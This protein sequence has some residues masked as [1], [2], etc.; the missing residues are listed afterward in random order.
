MSLKETEYTYDA[1]ICYRR[2]DLDQ[3]IAARLHRMLSTYRVP[4]P[5]VRAGGR[6]RL[7]PIFRDQE[8]LP[9]SGSLSNQL[10]AELRQSRCLLV[11]C[12]PR[13]PESK[14]IDAEIRYF[15][16][17]GREDC[18]LTL[19]I[20]GAP[21]FGDA[22]P[23]VLKDGE[24]SLSATVTLGAK[25]GAIRDAAA[26][27]AALRRTEASGKEGHEDDNIPAPVDIRDPDGR[28][29][30]R[31][32]RREK[33]KLL[34]PLLGYRVGE[35]AQREVKRRLFRR[36]QLVMV[37]TTVA[38]TLAAT[39]YSGKQRV[40]E[41]AAVAM[42]RELAAEA[43]GYFDQEHD[44]ALLLAVEACRVATTVEASASLLTG[45]Q[46]F[47]YLERWF[48]GHKEPVYAVTI[49]PDG[50][51]IASG[52]GARSE[53]LHSMA[54]VIVESDIL[55][56][57]IEGGGPPIRRY[58][59]PDRVERLAFHPTADVVAAVCFDGRIFLCDLANDTT[60]CLG[61]HKGGGRA[62]AFNSDGSRLASVGN[63]GTVLLWDTVVRR[64][65][66]W[67]LKLH[68]GIIWDVAFQPEG[69]LLVTVGSDSRIVL[70][71]TVRME[72]HAVLEHA[73]PK[74]NEQRYI[75]NG[76]K[77]VAFDPRGQILVSG[78][79]GGDIHLWDVATGSHLAGPLPSGASDIQGLAFAHDGR[80]L[81]AAANKE[82]VIYDTEERAR[83]DPPLIG[84]RSTVYRVSFSSNGQRLVSCSQDG[85]VALWDLTSHEA[86]SR[87]TLDGAMFNV[88]IP[89]D[90][91]VVA[92]SSGNGVEWWDLLTEERFGPPT[93]AHL[94]SVGALASSDDGRLV[95]SASDDH[96]V[97]WNV[98]TRKIHARL[99]SRISGD[100]SAVAF[101]PDASLLVAS[102]G[103]VQSE[104]E[105][106]SA[107][108]SDEE[109]D[110]PEA[111]Q[112]PSFGES[113]PEQEVGG[114]LPVKSEGLL[115]VWK[116]PEYE[117]C[118]VR[119]PTGDLRSAAFTPDDKSLIT[120]SWDGSLVV[121]EVESLAKGNPRLKVI[122]V[123]RRIGAIAMHPD[124]HL[125]AFTSGEQVILW[126]IDQERTH[127]LPL[128]AHTFTV[129]GVAFS[130]DGRLLA[131]CGA[132]GQVILWDVD[133]MQYI[134][135]FGRTDLWF[136]GLSFSADD[137][138]LVSGSNRD[139][140]LFWNT[141]VSSWIKIAC[142]IANRNLSQKE[143]YQY[144]SNEL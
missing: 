36:V 85:M 18:I 44:L 122:N 75:V 142:R 68:E 132:D 35:L 99:P 101:S 137:R 126:D 31:L 134:G 71:D 123:G 79:I 127:G 76:V 24:H 21:E 58:T 10:K 13:T 104:I 25:V 29:S 53:Q 56:W 118:R 43:R 63:E 91:N 46:R 110:W 38:A 139:I 88:T 15:R 33:I 54:S 50:K 78:G 60:V 65:L 3:Y 129:Y 11:V 117:W 2:T 74:D 140:V 93:K 120:G 41:Q 47:P 112:T 115:T 80:T 111:M 143:R 20:E 136:S 138:V 81:A 107:S 119:C 100:V 57:D 42:S 1:F 55:I 97:V 19:L 133:T 30:V 103:T 9:A 124:G 51:W 89:P 82:I 32:L 108:D 77:G 116:L 39:W 64:P 61:V 52:A 26:F 144:L 27:P 90:S 131:S 105:V 67:P 125:L 7:R 69:S 40:R 4:R 28:P 72:T 66:H 109:P 94:L 17:L 22:P 113:S 98:A 23:K 92:S 62:V 121:W 86:H 12:S 95:A 59:V 37:A 14:W 106:G 34:A 135:A 130:H 96:V 70:L 16:E 49:S 73:P 83:R 84:H 5:L 141:S 102:G 48:R 45:I 114:P 128:S 8:E 87:P 6:A